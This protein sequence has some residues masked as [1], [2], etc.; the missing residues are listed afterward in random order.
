MMPLFTDEAGQRLEA[1]AHALGERYA[2]D[3]VFIGGLAV[4]AHAAANPLTRAYALSTHDGDVMVSLAGFGDLR[5]DEELTL[6]R[7]SSKH[8]FSKDGLRFGVYVEH[9]HRLPVPAGNLL[10][11]G[12]TAA[13]FPVAALE[14]LL[15][16]KC[17]VAVDRRGSRQGT[18][19][20][21]D[22]VLLLLCADPAHIGRLAPFLTAEYRA[23][24]DTLG[25]LDVVGLTNGNPHTA[26]PLTRALLD[27][28]SAL[29]T[30]LD[31]WTLSPPRATSNRP[32]QEPP[33]GSRPTTVS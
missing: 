31:R 15:V 12:T 8:E 19:D 14:H 1:A 33:R 18:K 27:A 16:L 3:L 17:A 9:Q 10:A 11:A 23:L 30:A 4:A 32:Q 24:I 7:R 20:R 13:P 2:G 25:H 21:G 5:D 28:R 6:T 29:W 26:S 22:L